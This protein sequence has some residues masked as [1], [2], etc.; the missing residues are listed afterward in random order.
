MDGS[1][2][3]SVATPDAATRA[4]FSDIEGI[5]FMAIGLHKDSN[6]TNAFSGNI[7]D[8]HIYDRALDA[9]EI[10]FLYNLQK[11]RDQIPRLEALADAVGTVTVTEGGD[12]YKELPEAQ[13]SFGMDGNLTSD[14]AQTVRPQITEPVL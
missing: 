3:G 11:G 6:E 10:S 2:A 7:D 14:L 4:F 13:F 8:F 12:G 5:N 1:V 9:S